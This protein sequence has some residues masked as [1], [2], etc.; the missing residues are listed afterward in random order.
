MARVCRILVIEDSEAVLDVVT[1][2]IL[3]E[4]YHVELARPLVD[5]VEDLEF[6]DFDVA[7]I[8][9]T[10]PCGLDG[11]S[12]AQRA[13]ERGVG[14]I[15]MSGDHSQFDRAMQS[16]HAFLGKPFRMAVLIRL[17]E[18]VLAKTGADCQPP[19]DAA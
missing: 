15:L 18:D 1:E 11:F 3:I 9:L 10:L 5:K 4:G 13:A 8:D 7:I 17:I 2:S 19:R 16:A 6:A 12:L 14:V